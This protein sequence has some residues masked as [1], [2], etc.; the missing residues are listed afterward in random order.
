M[1]KSKA[2]KDSDIYLV[3]K[4]GLLIRKDHKGSVAIL[5]V[6]NEENFYMID[7]IAAEFWQMINGKKSLHQIKKALIT[8]HRPPLQEFERELAK[9]LKKL[10]THELLFREKKSHEKTARSARLLRD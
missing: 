1:I 8:K 10:E 9:C 3:K 2:A 7:G 5:N 4:P 6:E